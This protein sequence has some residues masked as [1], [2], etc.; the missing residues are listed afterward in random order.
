MTHS[1]SIRKIAAASRQR[2]EAGFTL[3]E[4]L[5]ALIVLIIGVAGVLTMQMSALRGTTYSRH[6]TEAIILGEDKMEELMAI[7]PTSPGFLGGGPETINSLGQPPAVGDFEFER[8]WVIAGVNPLVTITV[9]VRW[10]ERGK[11]NHS[12]SFQTQRAF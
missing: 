10:V 11:D 2:G 7:A 5:V 4:I 12:M 8:D 6:A 9:T 3:V 1:L